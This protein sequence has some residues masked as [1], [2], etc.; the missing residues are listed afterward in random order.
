MIAEIQDSLYEIYS[1]YESDWRKH[2]E[3]QDQL[4]KILAS[5]NIIITNLGESNIGRCYSLLKSSIS[6][7]IELSREFIL[8][9]KKL[10]LFGCGQQFNIRSNEKV[11]DKY[12]AIIELKCDSG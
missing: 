7:D 9:L 10:K 6:S 2:R 8:F 11:N 3:M 4:V 5:N 1:K 12:I